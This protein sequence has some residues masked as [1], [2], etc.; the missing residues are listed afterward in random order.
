MRLLT[1]LLF[2]LFTLHPSLFTQSLPS[3]YLLLGPFPVAEGVEAPN[4]VQEKAGFTTDLV[5]ADQ[6]GALEEGLSLMHQGQVFKWQKAEAVDGYVDLD[7]FYENPDYVFAYAYAEFEMDQ[8]GSRL[9]GVGSDDGIKIWLN[10]KLIHENYVYR[11][12]VAKEDLVVFDFQQGKNTLLIRVQDNILD[13]GFSLHYMG[14]EELPKALEDAVLGGQMDRVK[15]LIDLGVDVNQPGRYGLTP[16]QEAR[17][18]GRTEIVDFLVQH[19][20]V[21][22]LPFP[23]P[24]MLVERLFQDISEETRPG[25]SVLV[26]KDGKILYQKGFG[27][28]NLEKK[29]PVSPE[30]KFRIGS[31]SKQFTAVA[32]L[33]LVEAGKMKLD[34]PLSK[35]IPDFPRG[36]EVSI[37]HL[38]THTSGIHS[39]TNTPNFLDRVVKPVAWKDLLEEIKGYEYDFDPGANW[40]YNNS[41]YFILGCLVEQV[42]GL[43]FDNYLKKTFFDPLGMKNTGVYVNGKKYKNE[44]LGYSNENDSLQLAL[45]WDMSWA[46]GAGNLYSTV[47]DLYLWNEGIFNGKVLKKETLDKAFTPVQLDNGEQPDAMGMG[48]YGYGWAIHQFRDVKEISHGGGL[49]G[50]VTNL[51]RFPD[52]NMTVTVLT[53]CLPSIAQSPDAFT[54]NLM[55]IFA[56]KE[57]GAQA[58][59]SVSEKINPDL[60]DDY[61]GQYEYP[62]GAIMVITREGDRLFAKLA[63]QPTYE[64]FPQTDSKFF[65]KVTDA[66]I[67]FVRDEYG[68]VTHGMHTQGGQTIKTPRVEPEVVNETVDPAIYQHFAGEY[69]LGPALITITTDGAHLYAEVSGQ[70][71]FELFPKSEMEYFL[72]GVKVN[73]TFVADESGQISEL[74]LDQLGMK[75]KA[76]RKN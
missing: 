68:I 69:E 51:S 19:G 65:W 50:F 67:E 72:K 41:G 54:H 12:H 10:G 8:A 9:V 61:V 34:D 16:W 17:V 75:Q 45:D 21:T 11:P 18:K 44:A 27:Y 6:L 56:W 37:H 63:Y 35:Y 62:G 38:L 53:N 5:A 24:E 20:A 66:Q 30:T 28:A 3:H 33:K 59:F 46:G 47:G 1:I 15:L 26:A 22:D 76:V 73:I 42:S 32:T 49:H 71:V 7:A 70:P 23:A 31:I 40:A 55:E 4:E 58:S 36:D 60:L 29:I 57:L 14:P 52:Q 74:I 43:S 13:W 64:I 25:A 2:S 48:G 39:F